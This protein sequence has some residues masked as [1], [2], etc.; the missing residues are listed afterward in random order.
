VGVSYSGTE[1]DCSGSTSLFFVAFSHT[2]FGTVLTKRIPDSPST[3]FPFR[4][5]VMLQAC[6]VHCELLAA[7][8][9][10]HKLIN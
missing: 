9:D 2:N 1:T 4:S 6:R 3:L 8:A 5:L 7:L 10:N